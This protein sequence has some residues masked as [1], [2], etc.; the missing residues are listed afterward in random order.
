MADV[1][2]KHFVVFSSPGTFFDETSERPIGGWSIAD[3]L[4]LAKDITERYGAKPYGFR[5][6]TRLVSAPVDDGRGG[7][8]EVLPRTVKTSGMHYIDG[9]LLTLAEVEANPEYGK[10]SQLAGNMRANHW[11]HVVQTQNSYRHVALFKDGDLI[12]DSKTAAAAK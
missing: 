9:R 1:T 8:L 12:V 4:K 6:E 11:T 7:T 2:E 5:F 10:E 3:A